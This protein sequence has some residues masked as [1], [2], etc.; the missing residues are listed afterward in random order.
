MRWMAIERRRRRIGSESREERRIGLS[1][2]KIDKR[3][4]I[5]EGGVTWEKKSKMTE[6]R[7]RWER[8]IPAEEQDGIEGK[9]E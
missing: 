5:R 4:R 7:G 9:T 1:E 6:M 8:K 3:K 2:G